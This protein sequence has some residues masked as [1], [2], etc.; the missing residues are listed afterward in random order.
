MSWKSA[1]HAARSHARTFSN[2]GPF[3]VERP[4]LLAKTR[5]RP[6]LALRRSASGLDHVGGSALRAGFRGTGCS[7]RCSRGVGIGVRR[8]REERVEQPGGLVVG[9]VAV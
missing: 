1:T 2:A 7:L 4:R 3:W 6:N 5:G 9:T 8:A